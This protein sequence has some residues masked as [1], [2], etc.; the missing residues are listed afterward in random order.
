MEVELRTC[1][2]DSIMASDTQDLQHESP[3]ESMPCQVCIAQAGD[4]PIR[5]ETSLLNDNKTDGDYDAKNNYN[6]SDNQV[7]GYAVMTVLIMIIVVVRNMGLIVIIVVVMIMMVMLMMMVE[8]LI[9]K[10]MIIKIGHDRKSYDIQGV[11][12]DDHSDSDYYHHDHDDDDDG[13]HG[14]SDRVI[15]WFRWISYFLLGLLLIKI[16]SYFLVDSNAVG[17]WFHEILLISFWLLLFVAF[18]YIWV[19]SITV[20]CSGLCDNGCCPNS[21]F[22]TESNS[23]TVTSSVVSSA[24]SH[25]SCEPRGN[26]TCCNIKDPL[27][28]D[29]YTKKN[30]TSSTVVNSIV[31][32]S[33]YL[34]RNI[35][36]GKHTMEKETPSDNKVVKSHVFNPT[37]HLE[38]TSAQLESHGRQQFFAISFVLNNP[39]FQKL[40][41]RNDTLQH[42]QS[43][44]TREDEILIAER[45]L[46]L[47]GVKESK[48]QRFAPLQHKMHRTKAVKA[49]DL[50]S[51]HY[52]SSNH[53]CRGMI[54]G[55]I[56]VMPPSMLNQ[57]LRTSPLFVTKLLPLR[58]LNKLL[59]NLKEP[60]SDIRT[61]LLCYH[62]IMLMSLLLQQDCWIVSAHFFP[63]YS[64]P[65]E[66]LPS[67]RDIV[68]LCFISPDRCLCTS[69]DVTI[70][71]RDTTSL[72]GC[73][74]FKDLL[75]Q[76][77]SSS[78][79]AKFLLVCLSTD[80]QCWYLKCFAHYYD[81]PQYL[82]D[83]KE[84]HRWSTLDLLLSNE[85][86]P[87][88][89]GAAKSLSIK[90]D[91]GNY[92][93]TGAI[94]ICAPSKCPWYCSSDHVLYKSDHVF[95]DFLQSV[96]ADKG[97]TTSVQQSGI[98]L[99]C[100]STVHAVDKECCLN[101]HNAETET[102]VKMSALPRIK[103]YTNNAAR[104]EVN[105]LAIRVEHAR[106]DT[107][108]SRKIR[109]GIHSQQSFAH[110]SDPPY[111]LVEEEARCLN[112]TLGASLVI[113]CNFRFI[114]FVSTRRFL[115]TG[116][117]DF[118]RAASIVVECNV[119][120]K[121][122][123]WCASVLYY[124]HYSDPRSC[125]LSWNLHI[126]RLCRLITMQNNSHVITKY[127]KSDF[128]MNI[129][130]SA[131]VE[132]EFMRSGTTKN[133]WNCSFRAIHN[134]K[135]IKIKLD[136]TAS[137]KYDL[138]QD[139]A[140]V[141][142]EL[143]VLPSR[144][145]N[146][147]LPSQHWMLSVLEE[148]TVECIVATIRYYV[149]YTTVLKTARRYNA[150]TKGKNYKAI[151]HNNYEY[152]QVI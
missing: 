144:F 107:N 80:Q 151:Y 89:R 87:N 29:K 2:S 111:M 86:I 38:D 116:L 35:E 48:K 31:E 47:A 85:A 33:A 30:A 129:K 137:P 99:N 16:I 28:T 46:K 138:L 77:S 81:P 96:C 72:A 149:V 19:Y 108:A 75:C 66:F 44:T 41:E 114:G 132:G 78:F 102:V 13:Y 120:D 70:E 67:V 11:S 68:E 49:W 62:K 76:H 45:K 9:S 3:M 128:S 51:I 130:E 146:R 113:N 79:R 98:Q 125:F 100:Q 5:N 18:Y 37:W 104:H 25:C 56:N 148:M 124:L 65:P 58:P 110:Y 17:S 59:A 83:S 63:H 152:L 115:M 34:P 101:L 4:G 69:T 90:N 57:Q 122:E 40:E 26:D 12:K 112:G 117:P 74:L 61:C 53:D 118:T 97:D 50:H 22:I 121:Q 88:S 39:T 142:I 6:C 36:A 119:Q 105:Y 52:E 8:T 92:L 135:S 139:W 23:I 143:N 1:L 150:R 134:I 42:Y 10:V 147:N 91:N 71:M 7:G 24:T 123:F 14:D 84:M 54:D 15:T 106:Y 136:I 126:S 141:S 131:G 133:D 103:N 109:S 95:A 145:C 94:N 64:D 82:R 60:I 55:H 93:H 73:S 127:N 140:Q 27:S 43:G 21:S 20:C 32:K